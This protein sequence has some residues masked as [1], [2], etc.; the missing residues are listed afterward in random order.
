MS[1]LFI[2]ILF[3]LLFI[4]SL[5]WSYYP[6][7]F[8]VYCSASNPD[9]EMPINKK[10]KQKRE[11]EAEN[12]IK[13]IIWTAKHR[14]YQNQLLVSPLLDFHISEFG[15]SSNYLFSLIFSPFFIFAPFFFYSLAFPRWMRCQEMDKE[16][17]GQGRRFCLGEELIQFLAAL[18][19]LPRT[20]LNKRMNCTRMI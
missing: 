9:F 7:Y 17:K 11:N 13:K 3:I 18:A 10:R 14:N 2:I 15:M 6:Y 12:D 1:S 20:I 4:F 8:T 19:V 5:F 16:R